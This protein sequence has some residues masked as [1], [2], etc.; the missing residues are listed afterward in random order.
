MSYLDTI[1]RRAQPRRVSPVVKNTVVDPFEADSGEAD[2]V[3]ADSL[4]AA[5]PR[6]PFEMSSARSNVSKQ[7]QPDY[8]EATYQEDYHP[9]EVEERGELPR[10][11]PRESPTKP[12]VKGPATFPTPQA[13]LLVPADQ[14]K[15][16]EAPQNSTRQVRE[17][18]TEPE[19]Q[20]AT[21]RREESTRGPEESEGEEKKRQKSKDLQPRDSLRPAPQTPLRAVDDDEGTR[22]VK[23]VQNTEPLQLQ[24][25]KMSVE[26]H[27]PVQAEESESAKSPAPRI[28]I[29]TLTVEVTRPRKEKKR[30]SRPKKKSTRPGPASLDFPHRHSFGLGRS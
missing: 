16:T 14:Q 8:R 28:T 2:P 26:A 12:L 29:G 25:S 1:L 30:K 10:A 13:S 7:G 3:E 23:P 17:P 15:P 4:E 24:P 11:E 20:R 18:S 19:I 6:D 5:A 27:N 21:P 22:Q 9:V